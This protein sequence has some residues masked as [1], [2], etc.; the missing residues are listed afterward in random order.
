MSDNRHRRNGRLIT[1]LRSNGKERTTLTGSLPA[2]GAQQD[3]WVTGIGLMGSE[4]ALL[5]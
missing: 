2:N 1:H 4:Q 3:E 5:N